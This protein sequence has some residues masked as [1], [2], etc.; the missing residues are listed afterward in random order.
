MERIK[1]ALEK[2]REERLKAGGTYS[3][4]GTAGGVA[5]PA[6][7]IMYTHT[8]TEE[9]PVSF[10]REMRVITAVESGEFADSYKILRTQVLQRLRENHWNALAVTSPVTGE[11][12]TLTAI[13]LAISLAREVDYTVLLVDADLRNPGVH[14]YFGINPERGLSD[15]LTD[16]VPLAELLVHPSGIGRFVILP[17]GRPLENSSEMLNSPKM[18]RLVEE[19]KTRYSSRIVLFDLPPL[20][21]TADALAFSPY[22]DAA[23]LVIEEGKATVHEIERTT[24]LLLQ[25]TK[26]IGTVLNKSRAK[27]AA[28]QSVSQPGG[29]A[30]GRR[31]NRFIG[32]IATRLKA[33]A[34]RR[35]ERARG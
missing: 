16:D 5:T 32:T 35:S 15:Y 19:L 2:A 21:S 20:L 31:S 14:T 27:T 9:V 6:G 34:S 30:E 25:N 23:L 29:I 17:G 22:V 7:Q 11:G 1:Q 10:L 4:P 33:W 18:V 24:E 28:N 8:R 3:A 13:N 26:L 12:K